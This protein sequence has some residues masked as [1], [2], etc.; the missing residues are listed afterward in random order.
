MVADFQSAA[1]PTELP[2]HRRSAIGI[3][4]AYSFAL[5]QIVRPHFLGLDLI[6]ELLYNTTM[7]IDLED[8]VDIHEAAKR[9]EIHEE[10]LRRLIRIGTIPATKIGSQWYI[11]KE[12]LNLF[13]VTYD[14]RTGKRVQII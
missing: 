12:Q 9:L 13:A 2:R 3:I 7:A 11:D 1:L 4:I 10:S 6:V 14:R 5:C 8:F